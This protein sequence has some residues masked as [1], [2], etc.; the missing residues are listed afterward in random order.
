MYLF[1]ASFWKKN[2]NRICYTGKSCNLRL[3]KTEAKHNKM[4]TSNQNV[5][6]VLIA[7]QISGQANHLYQ[8]N[9]YILL[10]SLSLF[11][12]KQNS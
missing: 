2:E 8:V 12:A 4:C 9:V 5:T 1:S 6:S 10:I 7:Q 11:Y 3:I